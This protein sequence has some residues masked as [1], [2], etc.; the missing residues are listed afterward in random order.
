VTLCF[1]T[2][3]QNF[4]R[5]VNGRRKTKFIWPSATKRN[6]VAC[7][8]DPNPNSSPARP[9]ERLRAKSAP[10]LPESK[11]SDQ[12]EEGEQATGDN[13]SAVLIDDVI[14]VDLQQETP[15]AQSAPAS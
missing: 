5:R 1:L 12:K 4:P 7:G 8:V 14:P 13:K 2:S 15:G 9:A 10:D 11:D 6:D 3:C